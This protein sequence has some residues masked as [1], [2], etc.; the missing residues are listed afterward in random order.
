MEYKNKIDDLIEYV[1]ESAKSSLCI[2]GYSEILDK[3]SMIAVFDHPG[4][5]RTECEDPVY[6]GGST[7][8][9]LFKIENNKFVIKGA[10]QLDTYKYRDEFKYVIDAK[11][12]LLK[13]L[14][15]RQNKKLK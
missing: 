9:L 3:T 5:W 8:M 6:V 13:Y 4:L 10:Y 12:V 15:D 7:R 11:K 14:K 2:I 1:N